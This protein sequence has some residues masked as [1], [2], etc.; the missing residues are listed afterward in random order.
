MRQKIYILECRSKFCLL[1]G[2]HFRTL[3]LR[4]RVRESIIRPE[5]PIGRL[6]PLRH[7]ACCRVPVR[8]SFRSR[9]SLVRSF[10][11]A[12]TTVHYPLLSRRVPSLSSAAIPYV[13]F[14]VAIRTF[15]FSF[16][17]KSTP[18][19]FRA[20]YMRVSVPCNSSESSS[21]SVSNRKLPRRGSSSV[22]SRLPDPFVKFGNVSS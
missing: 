16:V 5:F 2:A 6:C 17:T 7:S 20:T 4:K 22:S 1:F 15:R 19:F 8:T 3:R 12:A 21:L 18:R 11:S 9:F 14:F 10:F 13:V